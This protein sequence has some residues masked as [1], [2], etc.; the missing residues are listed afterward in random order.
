MFKPIE[1]K[2][3]GLHQKIKIGCWIFVCIFLLVA[4]LSKKPK[5]EQAEVQAPQVASIDKSPEMQG[6][7]Q[8]FIDSMI[9][10]GVFSKVEMPRTRPYV[11]VRPKFR[12]ID[13][14]QKQIAMSIIYAFYFN[15][16][17]AGNHILIRDALNGKDVGSYDPHWGLKLD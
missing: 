13:F 8:D 15:D 7:R 12:S 3:M 10:Q 11:W 5:S 14:E 16:T 2:Q 1:V 17:A 9:K 6:K 4:F